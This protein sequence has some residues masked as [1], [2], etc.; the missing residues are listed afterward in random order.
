M[1]GCRLLVCAISACL[2]LSETNNKINA[3]SPEASF[4]E[5]FS[6]GWFTEN[7]GQWSPEIRFM[8]FMSQY[9]I[10][11]F[12]EGLTVYDVL[13]KTETKYMLNSSSFEVLGI[14]LL[15]SSSYYYY[16]QKAEFW[17]TEARHYSKL[18]YLSKADDIC[19]EYF[20]NSK[21]LATKT[22]KYHCKSNDLAE[23]QYLVLME[24]TDQPMPPPER[25]NIDHEGSNIF[26][27]SYFGGSVLDE[28]VKMQKGQN[29][30]LFLTGY[31]YSSDFPLHSTGN[32]SSLN[33]WCD[34]YLMKWDLSSKKLLF[35]AFIGGSMI[36]RPVDM[37]VNQNNEVYLSGYTYSD[38]FPITNSAYQKQNKGRKDMFCMQISEGGSD[39]IFSTYIGG[40]GDDHLSSICIDDDGVIYLTGTTNSADFPISQGAHQRFL[41]GASDIYFLKLNAKGSHVLHSTYIGGPGEDIA[42]AMVVSK[43]KT[44]YITGT[45]FS[46]VFL[47][48]Y[49]K[50]PHENA[51]T[52]DV[53]LLEIQA[54]TYKVFSCLLLE[55]SFLDKAVAL[56]I[57]SNGI[58]W[59]GGNTFSPDFPAEHFIVSPLSTFPG[60][61]LS[62][63]D[64]N[65]RD[66]GKSYFFSG[67]QK[68]FLRTMYLDEDHLMHLAGLTYSNDLIKEADS[69]LTTGN[70]QGNGFLLRFNLLSSELEFA[71]YWGGEGFDE[72]TSLFVRD[73][74]YVWVTGTTSSS[75]FPVTSSAYQKEI[76]GSSNGFLSEILC[77][78]KAQKPDLIFPENNKMDASIGSTFFWSPSPLPVKYKFFLFDSQ[79]NLIYESDFLEYHYFI[80]PMLLDHDVFYHWMVH[81]FNSAGLMTSS[82]LFRFKTE[83]EST[84][85]AL[86]VKTNKSQY[87]YNDSVYLK[88]CLQNTGNIPLSEIALHLEHSKAFHIL[89]LLP[90]FDYQTNETQCKISLPDISYRGCLV[91]QV[92]GSILSEKVENNQLAIVFSLFDKGQ[93]LYQDKVSITILP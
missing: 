20:I 12:D 7:I 48:H 45:T 60:I 27:S 67:N 85:L 4:Q 53:F 80:L 68:D 19:I 25:N 81:L 9:Q 52:G 71:T 8:A 65:K 63:W 83:T 35:S 3:I 74:D 5:T 56:C 13:K 41:N 54:R 49:R 59:I 47:N 11:F 50:L 6:V 29:N 77:I 76:K 70:G 73:H 1:K 93:C 2:I 31:T 87:H 10:V 16:G 44:A 34:I 62:S 75:Q 30:C 40:S 24:S 58:L 86:M 72:I 90:D 39:I 66:K 17:G 69:L 79:T 32:R 61:F 15:P 57:D 28:T 51:S 84:S 33:G 21:G 88:F 38:N 78:T 55:G 89:E 82:D 43:D 14:D 26:Y 23:S 37:L 36:D 46:S 42:E 92:K 18:H 91:F 22:Q 64:S